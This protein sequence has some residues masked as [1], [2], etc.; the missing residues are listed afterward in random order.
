MTMKTDDKFYALAKYCIREDVIELVPEISLEGA[1]EKV[2][3]I[4]SEESGIGILF[5]GIPFGKADY[6]VFFKFSECS[7]FSLEELQNSINLE[8]ESWLKQ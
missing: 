6:Y 3:N 8:K 1:L 4:D 7:H 5:N 2:K